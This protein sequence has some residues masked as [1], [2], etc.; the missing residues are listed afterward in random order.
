ML[1][2]RAE[3]EREEAVGR[4]TDGELEREDED[5]GREIDDED[6]DGDGDELSRDG[7]RVTVDRDV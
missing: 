3:D 6:R 1:R 4:E 7:A 5:E 2:D